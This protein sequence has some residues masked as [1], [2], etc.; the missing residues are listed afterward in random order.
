MSNGTTLLELVTVLTVVGVLSTIGFGTGRRSVDHI[1]A[2]AAREEAVAL[3]GEA[4][5]RARLIGE[6]TVRF[7]EGGAAVLLLPGDSVAAVVD[8]PTRGV[9]LEVQG[10]RTAVDLR[11]G[12]L[13]TA[14]MG[15]ATLHFQ[16]GRARV[17]LTVSSYGRLRR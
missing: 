6:A 10:P 8:L 15:A 14:R 3:I 17:S 16:R 11:F 12:P 4:R 9:R 7:E 2:R 1:E 13:G 5:A